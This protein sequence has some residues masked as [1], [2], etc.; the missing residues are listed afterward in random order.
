MINKNTHFVALMAL[1]K[2]LEAKR[3]RFFLLFF[4]FCTA[5]S[6]DY[7]NVSHVVV[8]YLYNW[9]SRKC[10]QYTR[11]VSLNVVSVVL[12]HVDV[13]GLFIPMHLSL[14]LYDHVCDIYMYLYMLPL[15]H[16]S[17]QDI[18]SSS[19]DET[20]LNTSLESYSADDSLYL[21]TPERMVRD[22]R[23]NPAIVP[24]N[25][26]FMDL[27]QLDK[28]M[29]QVNEMRVCATLGCK[30][31]LTPVR[32]KSVGQGGAVSISYVC[33][34]CGSRTA[35]LETSAKYELGDSNDVS[36]AAQVA[37]II[38]GCTHA[39]YYKILK[40]ALGMEAV[41]WQTFQ[42][43]IKRIYP[44]VKEMVDKMCEDAK[45][46]MQNMDQSELG[47]WSH[48]VTSADGTW[49]TRGFHS[50]N[51]T[52][53]VR[54]Y[55][56]GALL[57]RKHLCQK[58]RDN[59]VNEELYRG[60]SKG[61]E[62]YAARLTF[63][64]AKDEGMNIAIQWQDADS[65]SSKAVTEHFPDAKVMICGGHAG[66]AH[67]K[68][69]EKLQKVKRFTA[70]L[71]KKHREKFPSVGDVVCHCVRHKPGCGC[72]SDLFIERSRNN[73]SLILSQS[74]SAEE[75]ATKMRVLARHARDEHEW[76]DGRC[77]FHPL[78][79][80]SCNECNDG[81]DLK[82]EGKDY[83][84]RYAL[85]CPF[86]SLA[87]EIEC[88]GRAEMSCQLIH[89]ILKRGHSNWLEASH[90]VFIRFR[91]KH[92]HLE[93][94][95]YVVST[96]LALLQSN[97]TYMYEKRGEQ[98][99]WVV[100]LFRR[101]K[102]PVFDGVQTALED[103]NKQRKLAL[104]HQKTDECKQRRIQLKVERT[105]DTQR[106]KEW[107]KK[108]GQDTYG[109]DDD[110]DDSEIK[111]KGQKKHRQGQAST[112]R[113]CKA[114]GL[115]SHQRSNH[116]KCPFNKKNLKTGT[117]S[118]DDA[119]E[120]S[121]VICLTEDDQSD[122][123]SFSSEGRV[124]SPDSWCFEDDIIAGDV[125]TC[126][127]Q[128]RA[129]MKDC[130][131]NSR[132]LYVRT[133]L[134]PRASSI[135][136][137]ADG[138]G[139]S[140][141]P[142][143][144]KVSTGPTQ[145]GKRERPASD[146]P[147]PVRKNKPNFKVGDY[148]GLHESK[149]DEYHIPCRVVQMFGER[150]LLYCRK[151]VLRTGYAK[152]RLVALSSE[153]SISV[154][155]WRTAA[156]VSLREVTSDPASLEVC[157]C[158][159]ARP[160]LTNESIVLSSDEESSAANTWLTTP[161]YTLKMEKKEEVLSSTGWLSDTVISAAQLLILQEFP[162]IAGLQNPTVHQCLSFQVLRGEFVQII[163]VGGC[164]W[165]TISNV[166]CNDGVVNVYD[167]M[168]PSVSSSTLK[169]IASLMFSRAKKL[170]VRIM[171]VGR[172]CNGSDCG[173][174]AIAFAYDICSGNDPCKV[175]YDHRLIRRHLADCLENCSLS[176]FPVVGERRTTGVR[177]TQSVDLHCSCRLPEEEGDK[178]AECDVCKTWYHQ[179]CMD[180]PDNVFD[181]ET[182]VTWKC[183][184]C[185]T[186]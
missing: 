11:A 39:T 31:K 84:T 62:G 24:S 169:L 113:R 152:S 137:Q 166:G 164:H 72:M 184:L 136:S 77:D 177:H 68:Q 37:F 4:K 95:H 108:H 117:S 158:D 96:E 23:N 159:I 71:I 64:K 70:P 26:C 178:M 44:I 83:H 89:P 17:L 79:L 142:K 6:N 30:G 186:V 150:C 57:Y 48:A 14:T 88:H 182:E 18:P 100:E 143:R 135:E 63:K 103:F 43:T 59:V 168:Y 81:D 131:L 19:D 80:C 47:S 85:T 16:P 49:M 105:V 60:T 162:R 130:P 61:A 66:R 1:V 185:G 55:Y 176:P 121:D 9:L 116:S 147:P 22:S 3:G 125:C 148:V 151:G 54:N 173:V 8:R 78:R 12:I 110:E 46:D 114:C 15:L 124:P 146:K 58:G 133:T 25:V 145:L 28:F 127:A 171:D 160:E 97:M 112:G 102:L 40:Q 107:S 98:Y 76:D 2:C 144:S 120:N 106:R 155:N 69:L 45:D 27:T 172:Q 122:A 179:H 126:G 180:I 170:T 101:L 165:C 35:L 86:H 118:D 82:C 75:F 93:Q 20:H 53:S 73:F 138:C 36:I 119:S 183:K 56:N 5:P 87:Y 161:L 140:K 134:F 163:H 99:H 41:G 67:K 109:S 33:N 42:S 34:G 157:C 94:L 139:K 115:S 153:L 29:K 111:S 21:P 181:D 104:D 149:L 128:G 10:T 13:P 132:N 141:L 92:I 175:K 154:E 7:C 65:S 123:E 74:E 50:K 129:H 174:L 51:A 91:P 38:A 167:S 32:V 156:K 90:N 52:F